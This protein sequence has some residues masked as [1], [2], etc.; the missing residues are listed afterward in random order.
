MQRYDFFLVFLLCNYFFLRKI[1]KKHALLS[2][3]EI[4]V[5]YLQCK[6]ISQH[7]NLSYK[8]KDLIRHSGVVQNI[9]GDKISVLIVQAAACSGCKAKDLCSSSESKEKIINVVDPLA[10]KYKIGE[11]VVV[12]SALTAG[13]LAVR[14][15]FGIPL[16][17]IV[18]WSLLSIIVLHLHELLTTGILFLL[19]F[20]YFVVLNKMQHRFDKVLTFW[21]DK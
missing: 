7:S 5:L 16:L 17:I 13:K 21:I 15:A 1:E 11:E 4:K 6:M 9:E 19:L 8:M 18:L 3:L 2:L 20:I 14:L 10:S 12:C